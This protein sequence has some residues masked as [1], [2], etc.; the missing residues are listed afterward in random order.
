MC[1]HEW[2]S[3]EMRKTRAEAREEKESLSIF[4]SLLSCVMRMVIF[5][6][7]GFHSTD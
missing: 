1:E 2:P 4:A 7:R 5:V 3:C 6:P